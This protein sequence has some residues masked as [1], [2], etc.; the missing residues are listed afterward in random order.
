MPAGTSL[1][2]DCDGLNAGDAASDLPHVAD[3][4]PNPFDRRTDLERRS[5]F[6]HTGSWNA[7][8]VKYFAARLRSCARGG[9][10]LR[11]RTPSRNQF[12]KRKGPRSS[13]ILPRRGGVAGVVFPLLGE[14]KG[15]GGGRTD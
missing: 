12:N 14:R 8:V 4:R 3:E 15:R 7:T 1:V 11:G 6:G 2:Q 13:P 9:R 5:P 10:R